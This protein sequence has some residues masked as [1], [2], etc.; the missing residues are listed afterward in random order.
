[1]SQNWQRT[2][3]YTN[4]HTH[5]IFDMLINTLLYSSHKYANVATHRY[6]D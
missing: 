1:M 4:T 2:H 5:T 3:T 6:T